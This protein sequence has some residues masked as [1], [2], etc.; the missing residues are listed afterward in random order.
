[1]LLCL[2]L[3]SYLMTAMP[4]CIEQYHGIVDFA[5]VQHQP[6]GL[7]DRMLHI[8]ISSHSV[9]APFTSYLRQ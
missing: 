5:D 6:Y 2:E 9:V 3:S 1:M 8:H 7:N 4:L